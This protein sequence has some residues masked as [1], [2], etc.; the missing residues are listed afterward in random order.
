[1]AK[2]IWASDVSVSILLQE[3]KTHEEQRVEI[4]H[5]APGPTDVD[6]LHAELLDELLTQPK[7]AHVADKCGNEERNVMVQ[8]WHK[9][10]GVV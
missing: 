1:M 10:D 3:R 9:L 8:M 5:G 6:I 4:A 7:W 2:W